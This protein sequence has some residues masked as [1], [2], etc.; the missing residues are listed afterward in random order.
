M[1]CSKYFGKLNRLGV[2]YQCD[3]QT[4]RQTGEQN[5]DNNSMHA[6]NQ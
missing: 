3:R 2:D 1:W 4:D 6:K 5:Y